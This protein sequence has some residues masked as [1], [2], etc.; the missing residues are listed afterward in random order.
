MGVKWWLIMV[1][2]CE[3]LTADNVGRLFMGGPVCAMNSDQFPVWPWSLSLT[4]P[5]LEDLV[6]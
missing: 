4:V 1:L 6:F 3:A 5:G 2:I